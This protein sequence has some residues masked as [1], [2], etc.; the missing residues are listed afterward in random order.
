V[1]IAWENDRTLKVETDNGQ[2]VRRLMF[3]SQPRHAGR[4]LQGQSAAEWTRTLPPSNPFGLAFPGGPPPPP[5][6]TLKVV[7]THTNG[8]WLRRNGVPYSEN[9]VVTEYFD[10]FPV[11][12]GGEWFV[13]TTV[14][15]DPTYLLRPFMTSSHFRRELDDSKWRPRPCRM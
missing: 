4:T 9:A 13:V 2:Q 7:T 10:R 8:G 1:R 11:P 5:G 12:N 3:G 6:G 14:V 15:D